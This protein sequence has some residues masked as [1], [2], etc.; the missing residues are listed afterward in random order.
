MLDFHV[1]VVAR[2]TQICLQFGRNI[3]WNGLVAT[4]DFIIPESVRGCYWE[5][6][7]RVARHVCENDSDSPFVEAWI[8]NIH[9][10][11]LLLFRLKSVACLLP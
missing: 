1:I 9:H 10:H 5:T 7:T 11:F 4:E 6:S 3:N 8:L 2:V